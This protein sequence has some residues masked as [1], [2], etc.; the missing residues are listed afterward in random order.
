MSRGHDPRVPLPSRDTAQPREPYQE[1]TAR[2]G[3]SP[4]SS[5][6]REHGPHSRQPREIHEMRGR[7]YRLRQSEVE[8]MVEL[9]K[10]RAIAQEDLIEFFYVGDQNRFRTDVN[11][12]IRQ[13]LVLAKT[14]P[15]EPTGSRTLLTLTKQGCRFLI[16]TE[17]AG[18]D[19]VLY[20]GFAKPREAHHDVDLYRLYQQACKKIEH[21][22]GKNLRVMLDYE[23]KKRIYQDL[24]KLGEERN[25]PARKREVAERHELQMVRGTIPVPDIRIEYETREGENA[26]IDLELA[27]GHY[28]GR[29][30]AEKICAGFAIYAHGDEVSKMRKVLDQH[31]LTAEILSL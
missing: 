20:H 1:Q 26:R 15:H 25:S 9:G 29:S 11:N 10:F 23:M 21:Q 8:A 5:G 31:G 27:T 18:K 2:E 19:Q 3:P 14:I 13:G 12:L 22:G 28:R 24:A 16:A 30:L 4:S 7:T 6:H 17:A